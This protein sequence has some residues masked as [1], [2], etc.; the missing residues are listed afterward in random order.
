M[1]F[2]VEGEDDDSSSELSSLRADEEVVVVMV[3]R[4]GVMVEVEVVRGEEV[5]V[6]VVVVGML[7]GE[8]LVW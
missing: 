8:E 2:S 5:N 4:A 3:G 1:S 6:V 7:V